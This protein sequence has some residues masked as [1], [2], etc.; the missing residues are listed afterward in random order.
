MSNSKK[1][2]EPKTKRS[3]STIPI[4]GFTV[5]C[6]AGWRATQDRKRGRAGDLWS[7]EPALVLTT[8]SGT[9]L[10]RNNLAR[11]HTAACEAADIARI[12]PY[13]LRHIAITF[14]LD[15]GHEARQV[16]DWAG[17]SERMISDIYHQRLTRV[18]TV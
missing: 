16:A 3:R 14:Q 13:E 7:A 10:N 6:L 9:P 8:R 1:L 15:A 4:D 2:T 17:T 5:E 18:S 12:V 11:M